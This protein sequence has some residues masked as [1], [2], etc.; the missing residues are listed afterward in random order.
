M[1]S[2]SDAELKEITQEERVKALGMTT[3]QLTYVPL[4]SLVGL[5]LS[6][7]LIPWVTRAF[8]KKPTLIGSAALTIINV[9]VPIV[10]SLMGVSWFPE[11]GS[12]ALLFI[13][14]ISALITATLGPIIF[15]TLN[16]MF[17]DITDEHE[18]EVGER[19]EGVIFAARA[20]AVKAT[21]SMG[22]IFGGILL[23]YIQFPRGAVMGE[24]PAEISWQLGFIAG[25][26]TSVITLTGL[27]LYLGYRIDRNRHAEI[28][29]ELDSRSEQRITKELASD[30]D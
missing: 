25:P 26:A 27:I 20:F 6:I 16:S 8:D 23:D 1:A 9:N 3:E 29:A 10:L 19:R 17:A 12:T 11:P 30:T 22:L 4:G 21:S 15:A 28:M 18:L 5:V 7:L 13:L 14:I 24:V 2:V